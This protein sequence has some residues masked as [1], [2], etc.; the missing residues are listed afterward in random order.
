MQ[1]GEA[2]RADEVRRVDAAQLRSSWVKIMSRWIA[3]R[4]AG[5]TTT[6]TSRTPQ[7]SNTRSQR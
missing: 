2:F 3:V 7:C 6:I 4:S 5:M 1:H